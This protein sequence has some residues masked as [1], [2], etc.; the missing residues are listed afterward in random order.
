MKRPRSGGAVFN[1]IFN[2][3]ERSAS[4]LRKRVGDINLRACQ[5]RCNIVTFG[6]ERIIREK[7]ELIDPSLVLPFEQQVPEKPVGGIINNNYFVGHSFGLPKALQGFVDILAGVV[8]EN[9]DADFRMLNLLMVEYEPFGNGLGSF[10]LIGSS[11]NGLSA[12]I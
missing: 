6:K 8:G 2:A 5:A 9:Q 12:R 3:V 7:A 10:Q 4:T 1:D 11:G